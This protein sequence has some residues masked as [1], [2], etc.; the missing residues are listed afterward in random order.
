MLATTNKMNPTIESD[1]VAVPVSSPKRQRATDDERATHS[2]KQ[3]ISRHVTWA[4]KPEIR[5]QE[6]MH[7]AF[8]DYDKKEIWYS[9]S[10]VLIS[11][12]LLLLLPEF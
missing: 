10:Y 8:S 7:K 5:Q 6:D 2:K 12:R 3:R 4:E 11:P 9:V 1:N